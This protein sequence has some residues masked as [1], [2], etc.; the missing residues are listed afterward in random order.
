M[1]LLILLVVCFIPF[2]LQAACKCN[3]NPASQTLCASSY[4]IDNP[5]PG[6]C[7]AATPGN[8]PLHTACPPVMVYNPVSQ[9]QELK[10]L[11]D[12]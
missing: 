2:Q 5:C 10:V 12:E 3:C 1:K 4:D 6:M 7:P 8:A 9:T 11:C